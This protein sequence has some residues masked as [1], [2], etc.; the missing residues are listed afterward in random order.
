M[1]THL[2]CPKCHRAFITNVRDDKGTPQDHSKELLQSDLKRID[3]GTHEFVG[4]AFDDCSGVLKEFRWWKD[5]LAEAKDNGLS[6]PDSPQHG[7]NY[8]LK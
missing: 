4:C 7:V 3:Y 1:L 5:V 2:Y 6:W 8:E